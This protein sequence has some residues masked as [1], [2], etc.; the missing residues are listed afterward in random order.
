[1]TAATANYLLGLVVILA[2][3]V[4]A[5]LRRVEHLQTCLETRAKADSTRDER[6]GR[7]ERRLDG[8]AEV[9]AEQRGELAK[10]KGTIASLA[11]L[12]RED[13]RALRTLETE[14]RRSLTAALEPRSN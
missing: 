9:L 12:Q 3:L 6:L 7:A 8:H 5:L 14:G 10:H 2:G 1:M 13:H 11:D 4:I